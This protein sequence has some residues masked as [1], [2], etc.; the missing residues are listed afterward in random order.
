MNRCF[1]FVNGVFGVIL[2]FLFM[3]NY[4]LVCV[5]TGYDIRVYGFALRV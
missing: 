1:W 4:L 2:A 3:D 5:V